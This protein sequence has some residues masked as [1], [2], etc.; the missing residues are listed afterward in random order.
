MATA[1]QYMLSHKAGSDRKTKRLPL[2]AHY[3]AQ[4]ICRVFRKRANLDL[5]D[6]WWQRE[7]IVA[8]R[9]QE[10]QA[11]GHAQSLIKVYAIGGVASSERYIDYEVV[12]PAADVFGIHAETGRG[13]DADDKAQEDADVKIRKRCAS[14]PGVADDIRQNLRELHALGIVYFDL[15]C[16]NLGRDS[17]TGKWK[18]FDFDASLQFE[19]VGE[20]SRHRPE[21]L[22]AY[23][24][25]AEAN[26]LS[27]LR[28]GSADGYK[29]VKMEENYDKAEQAPRVD[30]SSLG[31]SL[32]HGRSYK[33]RY[34]CYRKLQASMRDTRRPERIDEMRFFLF[35][36]TEF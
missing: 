12:V 33:S 26:C 4:G 34:F 23:V 11:N 7:A 29:V 8:A 19:H 1:E 10:A 6:E 31:V 25:Y 17:A 15:H 9:I 14:E 30:L 27:A 13:L 22:T 3:A 2:P 5:P 18:L 16:H 20:S 35:F 28:H 32:R 36:A 24:S 21:W